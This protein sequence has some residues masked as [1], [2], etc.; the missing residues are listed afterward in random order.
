MGDGPPARRRGAFPPSPPA[1]ARS[2]RSEAETKARREGGRVAR[3]RRLES[4]YLFTL[5]EL[6]ALRRVAPRPAAQR[7]P[8]NGA[9]RA[10]RSAA[11]RGGIV[12]ARQPLPLDR[13]RRVAE[14]CAAPPRPLPNDA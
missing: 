1:S 13:C 8:A 2:R 6:V 11:A 7:L 14:S 5:V 9:V 10:S 12:A 4:L 3:T